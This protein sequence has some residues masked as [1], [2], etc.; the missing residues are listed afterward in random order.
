MH[1]KTRVP[2]EP[3]LDFGVFT[4]S[5]VVADQVEFEMCG[6]TLIEQTQ[7]LELFLMPVPL[8]TEA[9]DL[10]VG[11]IQRGE[12][13]SRAVAF[14][15]VGHGRAASAFQWQARLGAV[16]NLNLASSRP[17]T[18]PS[19]CSGGF[20]YRPT[21][22]SSFSANAGSLLILKVYTMPFQI[23]GRARSAHAGL[24][25]ADRSRHGARVPMRGVGRL[26]PLGNGHEA[27]RP[28]GADGGLATGPW[29]VLPPQCG[30]TAYAS[31]T[32]SLACRAATGRPASPKARNSVSCS[33]G[34]A[35]RCG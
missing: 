29:C 4:G 19:A 31:A 26:L 13:S 3:A 17:R 12:Q 8:L 2:R 28:T 6:H 33:A 5:V 11:R 35:M 30:E 21:M 9:I 22:S 32:R 27:L 34:L 10:A 24:A 25:D 7:K 1:T 23:H 18:A 20:R 14:V 15:V 16:Q